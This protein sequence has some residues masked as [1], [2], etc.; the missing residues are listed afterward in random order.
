M[1]RRDVSLASGRGPRQRGGM[2]AGQFV[3]RVR[4][5][6]VAQFRTFIESMR[7]DDAPGAG[8]VV[9]PLSEASG[10]FGRRY[11]IDYVRH[12][13][14]PEIKEFYPGRFVAFE[15]FTIAFGGAKATFE[16]LFWNDVAIRHD[17]LMPPE[18]A[19]EAWFE[20]WFDP[21]EE[22]RAPDPALA[23]AVHSVIVRPGI[24]TV[25]FGTAEAE[26][27]WALLAVLE[28]A[29]A[30]VITIAGSVAEVGA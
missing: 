16:Q 7:D 8:E 1:A 20:R 30:T 13:E 15:P 4:E 12:A 24:I 25:D 10:V 2:D 27:L 23:E 19:L 26:A 11:R 9:L 6:Y 28:G 5:H 22:R 21:E 17:L 3:E 29:G 18:A 14:R